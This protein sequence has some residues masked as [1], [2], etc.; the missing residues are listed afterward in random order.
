[1]TYQNY[2]KTLSEQYQKSREKRGVTMKQELQESFLLEYGFCK[3]ENFYYYK[4]FLSDSSFI[5]AVYYD[6]QRK[7]LEV[8]VYDSFLKEEYFPFYIKNY[9][10]H[11]LATLHEEVDHILEDIIQKCSMKKEKIRKILEFAQKKYRSIPNYP[12][13]G[14]PN[15][16]TLT[17][18]KKKWYALLM[19]VSPKAI[20]LEGKQ[21][22]Y[23]LN[24]KHSPE[25]IPNLIDTDR[26]FPA[27]HMN[28]KHW[29]TVNLSSDISWNAIEELIQESYDL[30][31][32]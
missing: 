10:G 7:E 13:K 8:K 27:Y 24:L 29:I 31:N 3:K 11:F 18:S 20:G 30:V 16:C 2:K 1:M 15:Y 12:W 25:K 19:K 5:L 21:K 22:I 9:S 26:V 32:S 17:N 23:L 28:K 14:D 4:S 6:T